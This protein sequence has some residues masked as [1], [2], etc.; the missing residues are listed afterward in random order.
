[1]GI[2]AAIGKSLLEN[3][4]A[5][6]KRHESI[7]QAVPE[8]SPSSPTEKTESTSDLQRP[9]WNASDDPGL[10]PRTHPASDPPTAT[11]LFP[12]HD[13]QQSSGS[14]SDSQ[15]VFQTSSTVASAVNSPVRAK[16]V[17]L[18]A[19]NSPVGSAI[20]SYSKGHSKR[21]ASLTASPQALALLR[22]QNHELATQLEQLQAETSQADHSGRKSLRKLEKEIGGLR[23]ELEKMETMV[24]SLQ[25]K[26]GELEVQFVRA[27][28]PSV[29]R[30]PRDGGWAER[31]K[32][33][34]EEEWEMK[35][36]DL[37]GPRKERFVFPKQSR[38][39][40]SSSD[41]LSSAGSDLFHQS[42]SGHLE[43]S[44]SSTS[45]SSPPASPRSRSI[46]LLG[47]TLSQSRSGISRHSASP[48][49]QRS[50][51]EMEVVA[52]LLAKIRELEE[53][54]TEIRRKR[55]E[56]DLKLSRAIR[57]GAALEDVYDALEDEVERAGLE[58]RSDFG[59]EEEDEECFFPE[60]DMHSTSLPHKGFESASDETDIFSGRPDEEN[61]HRNNSFSQSSFA[62]SI[63]QRS[64]SHKK[65]TNFGHPSPTKSTS[66]GSPTPSPFSSMTRATGNRLMIAARREV[67]K[68]LGS[69]DKSA[70][71]FV[72]RHRRSQS[73]ISY[74]FSSPAR[75]VDYPSRAA[76]PETSGTP[77]GRSLGDELKAFETSPTSP[78]VL[79][80]HG[81]T[82]KRSSLYFSISNDSPETDGNRTSLYSLP[83]ESTLDEEKEKDK[84]AA[85]PEMPPRRASGRHVALRSG[86]RSNSQGTD[87]LARRRTPV[88]LHV[89]PPI[90]SPGSLATASPA[91]CPS[92]D[93]LDSAVAERPMRW[94]EDSLFGSASLVLHAP[95]VP[96]SIWSFFPSLLPRQDGDPFE[97]NIYVR[98]SNLSCAESRLT[99]RLPLPL[100]SESSLRFTMNRR[101]SPGC[102]SGRLASD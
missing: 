60:R 9:P 99:N 56:L 8:S 10:G 100:F 58:L 68:E 43:R 61:H 75:S 29:G 16:R 40:S 79:G 55:D 91:D 90:V 22:D 21:A 96:R 23:A 34:R 95:V 47:P 94:A 81:R 66:Y 72:H 86:R 44:T 50:N 41:T 70:S 51:A 4:I 52:Q 12:T 63:L 89:M 82:P 33:R 93:A 97:S 11:I 65:E 36:E 7:L 62:A 17:S 2:A 76:T 85:S 71:S 78:L 80:R 13:R 69:P 18:L 59:G 1:M 32:V 101:P 98:I 67:E 28:S 31:R 88:N 6:R 46:S 30:T 64:H 53:T 20:G 48:S 73:S 39:P 57:E 92:F 25:E 3:N 38:E 74:K 84:E 102:T 35:V 26:N 77:A 19:V 24:E 42:S 49:I 5:L 54:N 14:V 27:I 15:D 83:R 87:T 37:E 45:S